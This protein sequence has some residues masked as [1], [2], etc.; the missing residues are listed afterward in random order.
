MIAS[1]NA[2][3]PSAGSVLRHQQ[4]TSIALTLIDRG[5]QYI[6][7]SS[8]YRYRK[9]FH[10]ACCKVY[11]SSTSTTQNDVTIGREDESMFSQPL[12]SL[13]LLDNLGVDGVQ[14][15]MFSQGE[16]LAEYRNQVAGFLDAGVIDMDNM[17]AA[18]YDSIMDDSLSQQ[19]F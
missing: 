15:M 3:A 10:A 5:V 8:L 19:V 12:S 17:L 18:W 2:G 11:G 13:D 9:L 1:A 7:D 4:D 14:P 6:N 16:G